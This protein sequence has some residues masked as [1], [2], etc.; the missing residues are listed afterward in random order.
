MKY[1]QAFSFKIFSSNMNDG[2]NRSIHQFCGFFKISFSSSFLMFR[3]PASSRI[4][5]KVFCL[6]VRKG[7]REGEIS[8]QVQDREHAPYL[9]GI[10]NID[11]K[12][13][14][15]ETTWYIWN[16]TYLYISLEQMSITLPHL[17]SLI[18]I[19]AVLNVRPFW[20]FYVL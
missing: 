16:I 1:F 8:H 9:T 5:S 20:A 2:V 18:I 10:L 15:W 19:F 6:L 14:C 17:L 3:I 7:Y 12:T 11:N 13:H 4:D